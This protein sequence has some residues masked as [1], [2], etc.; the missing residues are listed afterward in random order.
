MPPGMGP[1]FAFDASLMADGRLRDLVSVGVTERW[2]ALIDSIETLRLF[3]LFRALSVRGPDL[4][5]PWA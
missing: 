5:G 4:V 2:P 1:S 3:F